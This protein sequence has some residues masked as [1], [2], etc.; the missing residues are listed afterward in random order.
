MDR[1]P[2]TVNRTLE[3]REGV[4][5]VGFR[6]PGHAGKVFRKVGERL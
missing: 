2:E 3:V 4:Q 6:F 1:C 5:T